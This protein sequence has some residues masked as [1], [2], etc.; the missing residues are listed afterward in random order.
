MG[1]WSRDSF[2]PSSPGPCPGLA[3]PPWG[4]RAAHEG[5]PWA[6]EGEAA[7]AGVSMVG[8]WLSP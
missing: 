8:F 5:L 6:T 4:V 2:F 7:R 1:F 3:F